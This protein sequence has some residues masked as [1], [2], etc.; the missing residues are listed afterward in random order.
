MEEPN[1]FLGRLFS[2]HLAVESEYAK[3][4]HL[5]KGKYKIRQSEYIKT[6]PFTD[7]KV[8][9][10]LQRTIPEGCQVHLS[11]SSTV[12]YAQLFPLDVSIPVYCNRGTSGIDGSTSTAVG[13]SIYYQ[14]ATVLITGDLSFFYDSNGL[15]N[16]NIKNDFRVIVI[17]NSGGGIFRILPGFDGSERFSTFFETKHDLS[18]QH[19]CEQH[20]LEYHSA[21]DVSS[22]ENSLSNFFKTS[23]I[24]KLLEVFTPRQLN[25]EILLGYFDFISS[26]D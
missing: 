7:F 5:V 24:P 22:L 15:W 21:T 19:L 12:R 18:A 20:G 11:N 17:N 14:G 6:I 3:E 25:D 1:T 9:E 26:E 10:V 23:E 13:G 4:W 8:F 2:N 16:S